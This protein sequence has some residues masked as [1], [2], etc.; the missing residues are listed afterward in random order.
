MSVKS[1]IWVAAHIRRCFS[2]GLT[3]VVARRGAEEAGAVF[4]R[5][6][7]RDGAMR[8]FGPPPGP[9]FD[10]LGVRRFQLRSEAGHGETEPLD[11][12]LAREIRRDPDIW[13]VDIDDPTGS[14]LLTITT[15][16]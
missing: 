4:V 12:L 6:I 13:I 16:P 1:G 8:L 5:V 11:D 2:E 7:M 3:A 14:G 15:E 9:A 10:A